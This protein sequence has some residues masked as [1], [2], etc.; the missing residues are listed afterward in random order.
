MYRMNVAHCLTLPLRTIAIAMSLVAMNQVL[1]AQQQNAPPPA[2]TSPAPSLVSIPSYPDTAKGL[3]HFVK[4]MLQFAM[5]G[6]QQDLG[7]YV[8]SLALP[9]PAAWFRS[10]FGDDLGDKMTR[11]SGPK[12]ADAQVQTANM[13][14]SEIAAQRTNIEVVRFDDSCNYRATATEYPFLVM[15]QS[16][17]HLYDVRFLGNSDG[18]LWAYF[19][20]VDGGFR[21]I[22]NLSATEVGSNRPS[23]A[24][25][26]ES[27]KPVFTGGNVQ[28]AR[29][30]HRVEPDY[31]LAAKTAGIQGTVLFHAVIGKDG[32]IAYLQLLQGVCALAQPA[33]EAVK[34]WRYS[35]TTLAG[36]PIEVDTTINVVFTLSPAH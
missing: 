19:A 2:Q 35:P 32:S 3:E 8:K 36:V 4:D 18:H 11:I 31:P 30:I 15:R 26:K 13:L 16:S 14:G 7:L 25:E 22:G 12:R 10:V 28:A 24:N 21:F 1:L 20:Y 5:E 29:L 17:E 27:S 6:K 23:R 33:T 9:D 34:K